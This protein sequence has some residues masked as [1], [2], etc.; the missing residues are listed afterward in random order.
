M[1]RVDG[2]KE[3]SETAY[4]LS[5]SAKHFF[6]FVFFVL[7]SFFVSLCVFLLFAAWFGPDGLLQGEA[8]VGTVAPWNQQFS[9]VCPQWWVVRQRRRSLLRNCGRLPSLTLH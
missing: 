7:F 9:L 1:R 4:C 5:S 8:P 6:F 2:E 3:P